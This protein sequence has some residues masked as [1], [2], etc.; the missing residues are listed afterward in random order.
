MQRLVLMLLEFACFVYA[1][2]LLFQ[3]FIPA[4]IAGAG[5]LFRGDPFFATA[6]KLG[7]DGATAA[8]A[9]LAC[10]GYLAVRCLRLRPQA[11][12]AN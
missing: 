7:F 6:T 4:A 9:G 2:F 11:C 1:S 8:A 3:L 5:M 12:A 10:G